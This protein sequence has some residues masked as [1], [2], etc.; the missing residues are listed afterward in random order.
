MNILNTFELDV[1]KHIAAAYPCLLKHIDHVFVQKREYTGVGLYVHFGYK[2]EPLELITPRNTFLSINQVL[3]VQGLDED[4]VI[5]FVL[6]ITEGKMDFLEFVT[7]TSSW[8]GIPVEYR[9]ID[10][11]AP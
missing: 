1:V 2:T 7:T 5:F 4:D 3:K 6:I 9:F 8:N 11:S 10:L